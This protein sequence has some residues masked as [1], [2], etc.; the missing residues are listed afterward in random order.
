MLSSLG[1]QIAVLDR[2]SHRYVAK[3]KQHFLKSLLPLGLCCLISFD[4]LLPAA[5]AQN[6][7]NLPAHIDILVVEGEGVTSKT[8]QRVARDPVVKIED[9]DHRP[10]ADAAVVFAL[11][12][13]GTTGEF[14][15]GS[16]TLTVVTDMN[17]QAAAHGLKT[18]EV[19]GKLQIY[20]TASY[21][22]LR[23]RTLINQF[24]EAV[25]GAKTPTPDLH[26]SKSGGQWKWIVLGIVAAGGAG[27]GVYFGKHTSSSPPI[28]ISTGTVVFGSPR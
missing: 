25:P 15:N 6:P 13:S 20:V 17:G 8:R 2:A 10:L 24:V 26:T 1:V 16:K 9:D 12:V 7:Q 11:P 27:A 19:P 18:N 4:G 23:A 3:M 22:G 28:S 21:H 14:A 5:F